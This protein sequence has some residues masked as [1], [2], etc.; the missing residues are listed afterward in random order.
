M[1]VPQRKRMG[2]EC[3]IDMEFIHASGLLDRGE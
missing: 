2:I 3:G 1:Q